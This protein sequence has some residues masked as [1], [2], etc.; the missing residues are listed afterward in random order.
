MQNRDSILHIITETYANA[1][2]YLN[3]ND[4]GNTAT[5]IIM[6][7]WIEALYI[8][9][10]IG[11]NTKNE[12]IIRRIAEQKYSLDNL[13]ELLKMYKDNDETVNYYLIKLNKLKEL[14]NEIDINN[15]ISGVKTDEETKITTI[16]GETKIDATIDDVKKIHEEVSK[17]REDIVNL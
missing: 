2:E 14:F 6:G 3:N 7:G 12:M 11:T 16:E 9:T 17:I 1:D 13:I 10:S 5:L 4:R 15:T 8:A